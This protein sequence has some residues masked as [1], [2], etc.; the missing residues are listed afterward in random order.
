MDGGYVQIGGYDKTGHFDKAIDGTGTGDDLTWIKMLYS[1]SDFYIPIRGIMMND[2][3]IEGSNS[4]YI[5]LID[6]GTTFTYM[7]QASFNAIKK[8]FEDYCSSK[9]ERKCKWLM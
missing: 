4:Q 3:V 5:G 1:Y 2:D 9:D 6:S 8:Q 7:S